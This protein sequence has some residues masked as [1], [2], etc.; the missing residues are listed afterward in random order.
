[1][2]SNNDITPRQDGILDN[3]INAPPLLTNLPTMRHHDRSS[4]DRAKDLHI[5]HQT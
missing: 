5:N 2:I 3:P 4:G 1:L